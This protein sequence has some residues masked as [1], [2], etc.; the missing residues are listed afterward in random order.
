MNGK[1]RL[2]KL[3]GESP[4]TGLVAKLYVKVEC[5]RG[6]EKNSTMWDI[7]GQEVWTMC[8]LGSLAAQQTGV[9][10]LLLKLVE[11]HVTIKFF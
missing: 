5:V 8:Q 3:S 2:S 7:T 1:A 10:S 4:V 11:V 6:T 9:A